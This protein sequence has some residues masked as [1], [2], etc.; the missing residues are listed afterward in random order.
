[1][2]INI[3]VQSCAC[4]HICHVD[5]RAVTCQPIGFSNDQMHPFGLFLPIGKLWA[6]VFFG[7]VFRAP[8]T[9]SLLLQAAS[10]CCIIHFAL[11]EWLNL[12]GDL[13]LPQRSCGQTVVS[14]V[15]PAS[16]LPPF[17]YS[18]VRSREGRVERGFGRLMDYIL[19]N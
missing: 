8:R 11:D 2:G 15:L 19:I 10:G 16:K 17:S 9:F 1:M 13:Y 12:Q 18:H 5:V 3:T 4:L 14:G 6:P 7:H